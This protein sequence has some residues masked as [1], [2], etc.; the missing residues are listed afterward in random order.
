[1]V[2]LHLSGDIVTC[3]DHAKNYKRRMARYERDHKCRYGQNIYLCPVAMEFKRQ[4][5]GLKPQ[6][7]DLSYCSLDCSARCPKY[8]LHRDWGL[9]KKT[10]KMTN[11]HY[12]KIADRAAWLKENQKHNLLFITLT[13]GNW[14]RKQISDDDANKCFSKFMENLKKNYSRGNYIAVREHSSENTKRVHYH[15]IIDLPYM[16]FMSVN[17]AWNAAISDFCDYSKNAF[18]TDRNARYIKSTT[19]AVRYIC[20]YI[21]KARTESADSRIM[22]FSRE[23]TEAE[24]TTDFSGNDLHEVLKVFRSVQIFKHNEFTWRYSISCQKTDTPEQKQR[25]YRAADAFFY[26]VVRAQF[27]Y[28]KRKPTA[29]YFYPAENSD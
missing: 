1:M 12:R 11:A 27:G 9:K 15:C 23:I 6:K 4:T 22:F 20:K 19:A 17:N 24:V 21:S 29:I 8:V 3:P 7:I 16:D 25:T 10:Y 5:S 13:F 18:T 28:L 14:K 26:Q 2:T